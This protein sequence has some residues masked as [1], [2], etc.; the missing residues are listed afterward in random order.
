[1][2]RVPWR[3]AH[4]ATQIDGQDRDRLE[5]LCRYVARPTLPKVRRTVAHDR[6]D[7]PALLAI[8]K[9][10]GHPGLRTEAP[11]GVRRPRVAHGQN[12]TLSPGE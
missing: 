6:A 7:H 5:E 11:G 8:R 9:V 4:A 3:L 2:P 12:V 10:L 1:M